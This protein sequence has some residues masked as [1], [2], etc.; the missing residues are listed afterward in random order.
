MLSAKTNEHPTIAETTGD[1]PQECKP[2]N[3]K[4]WKEYLSQ[5]PEYYTKK[6]II[7]QTPYQKY[8]K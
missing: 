7:K 2:K 3:N 5:G 4:S 1:R 8:F 6:Y